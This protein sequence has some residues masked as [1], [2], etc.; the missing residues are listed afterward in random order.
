MA[1]YVFELKLNVKWSLDIRS[2]KIN[3]KNNKILWNGW[4]VYSNKYSFYE[5]K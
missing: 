4:A 1:I 2:N 5:V 3:E